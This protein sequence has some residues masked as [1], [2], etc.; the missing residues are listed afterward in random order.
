M[1]TAVE[2]NI[3]GNKS[4]VITLKTPNITSNAG[5][6]EEL[7]GMG[8]SDQIKP[9][10]QSKTI[11]F[12]RKLTNDE[13]NNSTLVTR[14]ATEFD[15]V[16]AQG[17]PK[18]NMLS[19]MIGK[20]KPR[21]NPAASYLAV[22]AP[23]GP[24]EPTRPPPEPTRPPPEPAGTGAADSV[25]S[26]DPAQPSTLRVNPEHERD[27]R[28][29][30]RRPRR[31]R[32]NNPDPAP[33]PSAAATAELQQPAADA[34]SGHSESLSGE[35][36]DIEEE[37]EE[38]QRNANIIN[39]N[40]R[41]AP[42]GPSEPTRPPPAGQPPPEEAGQPPPH[43]ED[44]GN[45]FFVGGSF[46]KKRKTNKNKKYRKKRKSTKKKKVKRKKYSLKR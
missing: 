25:L 36:L 32:R 27:E 22:P 23:V 20:N 9:Q 2:N 45:V 41:A 33:T 11:G 17:S 43:S 37:R 7:E 3:V 44:N 8:V 14:L 30:R 19:R 4:N 13:R 29:E 28:N 21:R 38:R 46:N 34:L 16:Q 6:I 5:L 39:D 42:V 18:R 10:V 35:E 24:S 1:K 15:S 26:T 40:S 12:L 31:A